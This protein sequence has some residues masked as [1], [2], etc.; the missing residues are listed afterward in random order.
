MTKLDDSLSFKL[1]GIGMCLLLI[2]GFGIGTRFFWKW[3]KLTHG[4]FIHYGL[5]YC[6]SLQLIDYLVLDH[7][8]D[9]VNLMLQY[10]K[11]Y[12]EAINLY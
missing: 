12:E 2:T 9:E 3:G 10:N 8:E 6:F 11:N 4:K 1:K 7:A 5:G